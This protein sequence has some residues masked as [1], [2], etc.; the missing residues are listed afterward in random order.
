MLII[1]IRAIRRESGDR[2][3]QRRRV[4]ALVSE[5][6]LGTEEQPLLSETKLTKQDEPSESETETE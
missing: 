5:E 2:I 3:H 4:A 6:S 1:S